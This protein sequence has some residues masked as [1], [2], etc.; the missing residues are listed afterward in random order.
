MGFVGRGFSRDI[1]HR[2][3]PGFSP[4]VRIT[5]SMEIVKMVAAHCPTCVD[6]YLFD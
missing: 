4:E 5:A 1:N 6:M 3:K 2:E